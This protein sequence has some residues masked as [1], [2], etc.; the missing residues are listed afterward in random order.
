MERRKPKPPKTGPPPWL[1]TFTDL[2]TLLLT[3]FVLMLS[4]SSLDSATLARISAYM[5]SPSRI[6]M[7]G[8]GRIPDR[9]QLV[10]KLIKDPRN[11]LEKRD[12]IK[13]LLFPHDLL[14]K[15]LPK[16]DL[17]KNITILEHPEGV[18]IVLTEGLLFAKDSADLDAKGKKLVA[19]L[20]PVMQ[21][22]KT[23]INISGHTDASSAKDAAP[24]E[25]SLKRALAVLEQLLQAKI[26][27]DRFSVSGY[28]PDKPMEPNTSEEGRAKNRRV[29]ILV[30]TTPRMGSYL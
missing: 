2:M 15:E 7:S 13:D 29:E 3:F 8:A 27:P 19:V 10:V 26:P 25:L 28:G 18:V 9:I 4:M 5:R 1:I 12:R 17:E 20:A 21:A 14:P 6:E 30:K 16:G 24:Y 11:I 22:V 23:D